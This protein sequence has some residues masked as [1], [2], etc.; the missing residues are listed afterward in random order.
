MAI[1]VVSRCT[2]RALGFQTLLEA[3]GY[4]PCWI[5]RTAADALC[6]C[7]EHLPAWLLL[8]FALPDSSGPRLL[9][10]LRL[11]HPALEGI[12]ILD[13]LHPAFLALAERA[14]A[15]AALWSGLPPS[16]LQERLRNNLLFLRTWSPAAL[17]PVLG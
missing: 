17:R 1:A 4:S 9:H 15:R 12:V 14:G 16:V 2:L 8:D 13:E 6:R 7:R 5:A 11:T 3:E 10:Q